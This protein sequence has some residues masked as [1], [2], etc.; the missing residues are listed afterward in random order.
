MSRI[1]AK[2]TKPELAVRRT[3]HALG[4]R[5]R[6]HRRDLPG[7]PDLVFPRLGKVVLV[8]GCF[9]HRH[10]DPGCRNAV[11]PKTRQDWWRAKLS[12]NVDRD[13]RNL[14]ALAELG[15]EVLTLWE[16]DIRSG[17]FAAVLAAFLATAPDRVRPRRRPPGRER[18]RPSSRSARAR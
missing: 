3:A 17:A 15:W 6:L 1:A 9:W 16:C 4:Y 13:A 10:S 12:A 18:M 11:L 8:H 14:K 2:D 5:F 7:R